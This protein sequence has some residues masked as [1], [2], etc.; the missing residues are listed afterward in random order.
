MIL[1]LLVMT[2]YITG[3][4]HLHFNYRCLSLSEQYCIVH[5]FTSSILCI[6]HKSL[7]HRHVPLLAST[8]G[9]GHGLSLD[10][11]AEKGLQDHPAGQRNYQQSLYFVLIFFTLLQ[12]EYPSDILFSCISSFIS[13]TPELIHQES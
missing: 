6:I 3:Y 11:G 12:F 9:I 7:M 13:T 5:N 1:N 4:Y 10:I 8:E 2:C